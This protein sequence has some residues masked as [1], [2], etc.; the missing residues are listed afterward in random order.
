MGHHGDRDLR[1]AEA[2]VS[3]AMTI[4][5]SALLLV[6]GAAPAVARVPLETT[7]HHFK[8]AMLPPAPSPH[9]SHP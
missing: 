2:L 4:A 7:K 1:L 6:L 3:L 5:C 8:F 9:P